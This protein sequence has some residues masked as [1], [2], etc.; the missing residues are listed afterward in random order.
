[1]GK[2]QI[3]WGSEDHWTITP[4]EVEKAK[5]ALGMAT[6]P[7]AGGGGG[8]GRGGGGGNAP[9]EENP[10]WKKLHEPSARDPRGFIIPSSQA[11]FG[12]ATKFINALLK[13]GITILRAT[14]P[15]TVAG[16]QYPKDS[17]VVK[18]AQPFR[19][20]VMDM[21]EP[22]DHPDD[23]AYPGAPP[24]R[25]YDNAGWTLAFQMGVEFDRVLDGFDGPFEKITTE[26]AKVPAGVIKTAQAPAG[27]YFTHK[28]NDSV[29]AVMRL[30]KAGDD[31]MWLTNGPMGAG[32]FYVTARPSTLAVLQKAATDLGISFE[33]AATA[34]TGAMK[35]LKMPRIALFDTYGGGMPS[36]WNRLV[37][38]NFEIPFDVVYPPDLDKGNLRAKYDV[39]VFNGGGVAGGGGRGGGRGGEAPAGAP[40]AGGGAAPAG[41]PAAGRG[42]GGAGG[43]GQG[44]GREGFTPQPI[45]EEFA[46]RQGAFSAATMDK[47]KEFVNQGGSVLYI[48]DNSMAAATAFGLPITNHLEG[49]GQDKFYVPGSILRMSVDDTDP[50][51]AGYGKELDV[52]FDNDPVF[53]L[54]PDAAAKG[55]KPVAWFASE[56]AL[57]SGWAWGGAALNKGVGIVDA[58]VGQGHVYLFGPQITFRSQPHGTFKF[59][60]NG[61]LLSAA[62]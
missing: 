4:H 46:R 49:L 8:G 13:S 10:L 25:P 38:E 22:Q 52:F 54:G 57:R 27:Y 1:M 58:T 30:L 5:K 60:F 55:V 9:S 45:P 35:H 32:T 3:Q 50:I 7:A 40:A 31:V 51:A 43:R 33:S 62:K 26:L 44:G 61:L 37:F 2:D 16:K 14:A 53:K 20:H 15:F 24:T 29:T 18:T 12:T 56:E 19:A 42:A 28:A 47:V 11:D 39:I 41:A 48:G 23:F 6:A 17:Y 59:L 34:P 21:F 36:G